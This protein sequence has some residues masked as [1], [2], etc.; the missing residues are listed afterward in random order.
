MEELEMKL[1]G[2]DRDYN[3]SGDVRSNRYLKQTLSNLKAELNL[4]LDFYSNVAIDVL[5]FSMYGK[6]GLIS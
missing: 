3:I 2:S 5:R 1:K 6:V 4:L